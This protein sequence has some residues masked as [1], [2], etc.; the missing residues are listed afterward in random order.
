MDR[1]SVYPSEIIFSADVL[2]SNIYPYISSGCLTDAILGS[3][4]EINGFNC[5][6]Q[7]PTANLTVNVDQGQIYIQEAVDTIAYPNDDGGLPVNPQLIQKQGI[8]P[9]KTNYALP[10]P[11]TTGFSVNYLIQVAFQESDTD[12]VSRPY[13]NSSNPASPLFMDTSTTRKD[14]AVVT[15]K[16][17]VAAIT[18]TQTTPAPDSGNIGMWVVTVANGQTQI[19][20]DDINEY[21]NA[22]FI[23]DKL[24]DKISQSVADRLYENRNFYIDTGTADTYVLNLT[25]L[26][27]TP[28]AYYNGMPVNYF[29]LV[30]NSGGASTQSVG[31]LT[32]AALVTPQNVALPANVIDAGDYVETVYNASL[33]KFVMTN[34][35]PNIDAGV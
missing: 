2:R 10:A 16:A 15:S 28:P 34:I 24:K 14:A 1:V 29:A 21:P 3:S 22:P 11:A 9:T 18:G 33:S 4:T 12:I 31:G 13:Y 23:T 30:G 5:T 19:T 35:K 8:F 20:S 27:G 26:Y 25:S 6:P 7:T 17:G 32:A